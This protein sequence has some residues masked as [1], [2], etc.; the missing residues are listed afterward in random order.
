[1]I[2]RRIHCGNFCFRRVNV[3]GLYIAGARHVTILSSFLDVNAFCGSEACQASLFQIRI[4][5]VFEFRSLYDDLT[6]V[7]ACIFFA[8][9]IVSATLGPE[10]LMV[11]VFFGGRSDTVTV[12]S[13]LPEA[14]VSI[15]SLDDVSHVLELQTLQ[16]SMVI[17]HAHLVLWYDVHSACVVQI[18]FA[19][20]HSGEQLQ[21][22]RRLSC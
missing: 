2:G 21:C 20:F 7:F 11:P 10:L 1:M 12:L 4:V 22:A 3:T 8:V 15:P 17:D 6:S 5:A 13:F 14:K 16:C 19:Q 18:D 9:L